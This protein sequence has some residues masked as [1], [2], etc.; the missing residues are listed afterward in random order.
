MYIYTESER[1]SK[2]K[3]SLLVNFKLTSLNPL[4]TS[5]N[6]QGKDNSKIP[7]TTFQHSR[8]RRNYSNC[9]VKG[10]KDQTPTE[11]T[12]WNAA[13][14]LSELVSAFKRVGGWLAGQY[15]GTGSTW[16]HLTSLFLDAVELQGF[17][18]A[19]PVHLGSCPSEKHR[20][21]S[22]REPA[23][24]IG[25]GAWLCF[26]SWKRSLCHWRERACGRER[27]A[28]RRCQ[29]YF[30]WA[31][32]WA[33]TFAVTH[34]KPTPFPLKTKPASLCNVLSL[35]PNPFFFFFATRQ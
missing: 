31:A 28:K 27:Q 29:P 33:F 26:C 23:P 1:N 3:T 15:V 11:G 8:I 19:S 24:Q 20:A 5:K 25:P 32:K 14:P 34:N 35:P 17:W 2:Y 22:V 21:D 6:S 30:C 4:S 13:L 10:F 18:A 16:R 9:C 7:Q 12:A